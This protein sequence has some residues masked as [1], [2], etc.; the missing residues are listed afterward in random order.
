MEEI[1]FGRS[2]DGCY[3][4]SKWNFDSLVTQHGEKP[5][6]PQV[7]IKVTL[8]TINSLGFVAL[9]LTVH[10]AP[11]NQVLELELKKNMTIMSDQYMSVHGQTNWPTNFATSTLNRSHVDVP[12]SNDVLGGR[13]LTISQHPGNKVLRKLV[14]RFKSSEYCKGCSSLQKK[15]IAEKIYHDIT[16]LGARYLTKDDQ[17]QYWIVATK[18]E[19]IKKICQALRDCN[20]IDRSGYAEKVKVSGKVKEMEKEVSEKKMSL[21]DLAKEYATE[22]SVE[23]EP[24]FTSSSQVTIYYQDSTRWRHSPNHAPFLNYFPPQEHFQGR[25]LQYSNPSNQSIHH[26]GNSDVRYQNDFHQHYLNSS[27]HPNSWGNGGQMVSRPPYTEHTSSA[28][29]AIPHPNNSV[30][31]TD[32]TEESSDNTGQN[33][34]C[35]FYVEGEEGKYFTNSSLES[36]SHSMNESQDSSL[37]SLIPMGNPS[38]NDESFVGGVED[39]SSTFGSDLAETKIEV[40]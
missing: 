2:I 3:F 38:I 7:H 6:Q 25:P 32:D 26:G 15:S 34:P 11:S 5:S 13:G 37:S 27:Y 39:P 20:R 30:I 28:Q 8:L 1:I 14:A 10:S 16:T 18:K 31:A 40:V 22:F 36:S 19:F 21:Q 29:M 4:T 9:F 12:T 24:V 33:A 23:D 17:G 35:S